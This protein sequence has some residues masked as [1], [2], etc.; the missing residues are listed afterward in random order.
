MFTIRMR[1]RNGEEQNLTFE[2]EEVS[3]GRGKNNDIVLQR[4]NVSKRHA[5]IV[6][7]GEKVFVVDLRST[8]GTYFNGRRISAPAIITPADKLYVGDFVL[9]VSIEG[10]VFDADSDLHVV[11]SSPAVEA[12]ATPPPPPGVASLPTS[13]GMPATPP[14]VSEEPEAIAPE[15]E[16]TK[17][18]SITDVEG[19]LDLLT[20]QFAR[21]TRTAQPTEEY[22]FEVP[23]DFGDDESSESASS[24]T[25]TGDEDEVAAIPIAEDEPPGEIIVEAEHYEESAAPRSRPLPTGPIPSPAGAPPSAVAAAS[26]V[27]RVAE[28]LLDTGELLEAFAANDLDTVQSLVL[29]AV[30]SVCEECELDAAHAAQLG[31]ALGALPLLAWLALLPGVE[32]VTATRYDRVLL[33]RE[34]RVAKFEPGLVSEALFEEDLQRIREQVTEDGHATRGH[35]RGFLGEDIAVWLALAPFV[36]GAP[37]CQLARAAERP[38]RIEDLVAASIL[39]ETMAEELAALVRD[40]RSV[41]VV[42]PPGRATATVLNALCLVLADEAVIGLVENGPALRMTHEGVQRF[43]PHACPGGAAELLAG[44]AGLELDS[45]VVSG[46]D[47]S[48][49]SAFLTRA[50]EVAPQ[51]MAS[52]AGRDLAQFA[53]RAMAL[54]GTIVGAGEGDGASLAGL[55]SEALDVLVQVEREAGGAFAVTRLAELRQVAGGGLRV[56]DIQPA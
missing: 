6:R 55:V 9:R 50:H 48:S 43:N 36:V 44:L 42:G 28:R 37:F 20:P 56:D 11:A 34:G 16:P 45:L 51:V 7:R 18:F 31:A 49:L 14:P 40:G 3:V 29:M 15:D 26:L 23:L 38:L 46:V 22:E 30:D 19:A 41:M 13:P 2:Q 25:L 5:R 54:C 21:D 10:D 1:E 24:E 27:S 32:S 53:K 12:A 17:G 4:G 47:A 52:A 8:N 33:R 39:E 35:C